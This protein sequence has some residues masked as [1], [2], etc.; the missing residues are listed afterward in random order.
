MYQSNDARVGEFLGDE[1][2]DGVRA[3]VKVAQS[4]EHAV[5]GRQGAPVPHEKA[6]WAQRV[7]YGLAEQETNCRPAEVRR[8][9]VS[10][11][12][13]KW[14]LCMSRRVS[15]GSCASVTGKEPCTAHSDILEQVCSSSA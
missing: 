9:H 5:D 13:E 2:A 10:A 12:H 3:D 4:G 1:A 14:L 6:N 15:L 11:A 7:P 8:L